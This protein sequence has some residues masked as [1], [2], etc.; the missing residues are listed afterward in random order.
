[1]FAPITGM[2]GVPGFEPQAPAN[3][4]L[5]AVKPGI[6]QG[7]ELDRQTFAAMM[8]PSTAVDGSPTVQAPR[9]PTALSGLERF[10]NLQK[11]EMQ[12]NFQSI[13]DFSAAA[14]YLS[15]AESTA[16][17]MELNMKM[18]VATTQFKVASGVGKN[19]GK[20][21]DTLMRNQ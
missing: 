12:D 21:I 10:A 7:N 9:G 3:A 2:T 15:M 18:S 17:G 8:E 4:A 1:M 11:M 20:G 6:S 13:R 5:P 16:F 19:T 14:P